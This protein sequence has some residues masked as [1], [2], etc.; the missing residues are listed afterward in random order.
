MNLG[1]RFWRSTMVLEVCKMGRNA[2]GM[3]VIDAEYNIVSYNHAAKTMYPELKKGEKCYQCLM[4]QDVPCENCPVANGIEGPENYLEPGSNMLRAI[5]AIEVELES[6]EMGHALVF[7]AAEATQDVYS[8]LTNN[9]ENPLLLGIVN[10]LGKNYTNIY[11][12]NRRTHKISVCRFHNR[13][14]GGV[15]ESL[16]R[17]DSYDKVMDIYIE[18]NVAAEDKLRMHQAMDFEKICDRLRKVPQF[19]VHY[20]VYR[21]DTV[22]HYYVKCA[23]IGEADSFEDVVLAFANEDSDVR[24]SEM[25]SILEPGGTASR[26]KLLIIEDNE[27]NRKLLTELL[28]DSYDVMTACDGEEGLKLLGENYRD[29]S[30]V[31][32]DVSM[33]ICDGFQF[34]ERIQDDVMLSSVPV[35]VITGS[36]RPEDEVRCLEL[37][38]VDFIRKP[39]N[40]RIVKGKINSVIKLRESAIVL[41]ALEYDELTGIYIRQAFFHHAK[42]LMRFKQDEK[43]HV[44]VADVKN[45]KWINGTY[46]EKTGDQV[47]QYLA[48]TYKSRI[49]NGMVARYGGDQF[50]TIMYGNLPLEAETVDKA[51]RRIEEEAPVPKLAVNYGIYKDVD[52]TLSLTLICDRAFLA[53]KSIQDD[54]EHPFAFYDDEMGRKHIRDRMM[55]NE[56]EKAIRNEEFVV[57]LQPKYNVVTE[58]IAGAEALV[59]WRKKDGSMV[60][61]GEFI[62]LYEKDGLIVRLDEYVFQ[63]V[64][65]IQKNHM[66]TGGKLLP[67]SVNLS[68]ASIHYENMILRYVRIVEERGIP[69]SAV[70]IELT[71]TAALYNV[72]IRELTEK[73]V[74]A[75]FELHMDDFGSGYS[76]MTSLNQLPFDTL[77]LDKSLIDYIEN[78]RGMEVI[79]HTIALAHSL[80]MQVLAEGV[81]TAGQVALL[82]ELDCDEIQGFYYSRPVPWEEFVDRFMKKS[83]K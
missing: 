28:E 35:I 58:E 57:Y 38:A 36:N 33:P 7:S 72:Q 71:E 54:Y 81:E 64:C 50:V 82:R 22:Y 52:K 5:D 9:G 37:G 1:D 4:K 65:E 21:N 29:I 59:R 24:H 48:D 74:H 15:G 78:T 13:M 14:L 26:R 67:I 27:L 55:E 10:V 79:R 19:K 16:L 42:T 25:E 66:E 75:G 23:R 20:R 34:R 32:L 31:L 80:G 47:L 17:N 3:Y 30:A 76:S 63:K 69:F 44:I 68:R 2:S 8:E 56:F 45:F 77:K 61:P 12:V 73:M 53:M 40:I 60:S 11:S 46:G 70:P 83:D 49:H 39:Y 6:G 41:S 62:P 18:D 51:I 43:F